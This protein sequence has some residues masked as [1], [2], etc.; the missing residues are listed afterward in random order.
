MICNAVIWK[1][2]CLRRTGRGPT[3]FEM[4]YNKCRCSRKAI[5]NDLCKQHTNQ[6]KRR[7][8]EL[9]RYE[10]LAVRP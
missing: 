4:Y 1:R 5:E 6:E 2:D 10:C 8:S 3:G 9:L 7:G